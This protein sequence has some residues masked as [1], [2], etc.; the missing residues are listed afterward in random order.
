[1][2]EANLGDKALE[3]GPALHRSARA[4]EVVVDHR[5]PWSWPAEATG[6]VDEPVLHAR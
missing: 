1:M 3:A 6:V 4:A 2:A 5:H